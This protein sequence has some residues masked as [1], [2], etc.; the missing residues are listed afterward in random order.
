MRFKPDCNKLWLRVLFILS[1]LTLQ[2]AGSDITL[3]FLLPYNVTKN[4]S[5]G[6]LAPGSDFASAMILAVEAI[7]NN[8]SLLPG[9]QVKFVWNYTECN[10]ELSVK[11]TLHQIGEGVQGFIGPAC[12]C[13]T[14]ARVAAAYNIPMISYVSNNTKSKLVDE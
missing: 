1:L 14:T 11:A 5:T 9:N 4:T 6:A 2:T 3:G 10:D 12:M 7:T 8:S 13:Q